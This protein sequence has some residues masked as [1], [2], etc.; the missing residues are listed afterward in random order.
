MEDRDQGAV[1]LLPALE[2]DARR[3]SEN[4]ELYAV[5]PYRFYGVGKPGLEIGRAT[6]ENRR[7]KGT[8][9]WRQ[10][11]VQA[12]F[13]GLADVARQYVA[14]NFSNHHRGSRFPA[15]WGPNFDWIPDQDHGSVAMMALQS[16]LL[17]ADGGKIFLFP[18]WPKEWNVE[19]KLHAPRNT[20][21]EGVY[22]NGRVVSLKVTP[23]SRLK[24]VV[25]LAPQ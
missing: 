14:R 22:R 9:G 3:N 6:F 15:F 8:G 5:F 1:V 25:R 12:A 17:Q 16:M 18:A 19:F 24:D 20:T 2:F 13:L 10:D 23:R 11:A 21:I 7:V 4:P